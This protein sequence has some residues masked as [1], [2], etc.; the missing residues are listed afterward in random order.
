MHFAH[1]SGNGARREND[2]V[3]GNQL[4]RGMV[5]FGGAR[6]RGARFALASRRDDHHFV[7]RQGREMVERI[8]SAD[9]FKIAAIA[10]HLDRAVERAA[11]HDDA[12]AASLRRFGDGAHPRYVRGESR[13][14]HA[15]GGLAD[16]SAQ[17]PGDVAFRKAVAFAQN[18]GRVRR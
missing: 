17:G 18:I 7:A 2:P 3:A 11:S 1:V 5:T 13:H 12:T 4:D 9:T 15:A 16:Q 6:H 8:G 10:R 14:Q